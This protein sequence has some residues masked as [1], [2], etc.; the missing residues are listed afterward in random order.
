MN[1]ARHV[2]V[3][4]GTS[5]TSSTPG[6]A[7]RGSGVVGFGSVLASARASGAGGHTHAA[8]SMSAENI[9]KLV[10]QAPP[11]QSKKMLEWLLLL[12]QAGLIALTPAIVAILRGLLANAVAESQGASGCAG[13]ATIDLE[14]IKDPILASLKQQIDELEAT[15]RGR[16]G[17]STKRQAATPALRAAHC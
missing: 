7:A 12:V 5:T 16:K 13:T 15:M 8:G 9:E 14:N 10:A 3:I 4:G 6:T 11:G 17:R 2:A 1:H